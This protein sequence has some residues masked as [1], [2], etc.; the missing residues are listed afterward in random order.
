VPLDINLVVT[1]TKRKTRTPLPE[2]LLRSVPGKAPEARAAR[3]IKRLT[4]CH[5]EAVP[6]EDLYAGDHWSVVRSLAGGLPFDGQFVRVSVCSA[7]YGLLA[8]GCAVHSYAAT[9]TPGQDDSVCRSGADPTAAQVWWRLLAGWE[10]PRP[11]EP[12]TLAQLARSAPGSPLLVVTSAVYLLAIAED[13]EEARGSL[14]HPELLAIL[15]AGADT[16]GPLGEHLLS[17]DA[18]MQHLVGGARAS[19]NVRLARFALRRLNGVAPTLPVLRAVFDRLRGGRVPA[20]PAPRQPA[21][22]EEVR[23]YIGAALRQDPALRPTRLL[24]RLREDGRACEQVRFTALFHQV[25]EEL[26]GP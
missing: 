9:F 6:V 24:R 1:C 5:D 11:G 2:L 7:G 4:S 20:P 23:R 15:S 14:A 3:W 18:R 8:W 19:L 16:T 25:R 26:D 21:T 22:D 10:G 12:R 13:L 17:C